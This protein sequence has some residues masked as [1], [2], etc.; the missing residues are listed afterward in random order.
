MENFLNLVKEIGI[1]VQEAQRVPQKMDTKRTIPRHIKIKMQKVKD[2]EIILKAERGKQPVTYKEAPIRVSADLSTET[3]QA[4]RDGHKIFKDMQTR[5]YNQDY[6]TQQS[7]CL[8]MKDRKISS[9][10]RKI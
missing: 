7:Y 9:Q 3:L 4:R 6:P 5:T 1:Q 10:A 8:E 2:K